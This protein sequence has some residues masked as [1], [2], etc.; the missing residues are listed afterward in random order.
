[1][2]GVQ[3]CALPIWFLIVSGYSDSA[4]IAEAAADTP[5]IRKPF[6]AAQLLETVEQLAR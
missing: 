3:T 6:D 5:L 1:M 4:A 2:T